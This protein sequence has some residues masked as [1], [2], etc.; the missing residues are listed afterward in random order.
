VA[1]FDSEGVDSDA[2]F[3]LVFTDIALV[4]QKEGGLQIGQIIREARS[5]IPI[6]YTSGMVM[7][8]GMSSLFVPPCEFLPKPYR[9]DE[10]LNTIT[11]LLAETKN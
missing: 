6:L 3:D 9:G 4:D 7:T 2:K 5:G 10:L 11:R 1:P 8:D